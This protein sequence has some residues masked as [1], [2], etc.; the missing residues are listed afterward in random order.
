M[1]ECCGSENDDEPEPHDM[2]DDPKPMHL[3]Q[4]HPSTP[5]VHNPLLPD[6]NTSSAQVDGP[7][8]GAQQAEACTT[9]KQPSQ[10]DEV[11]NLKRQ[12]SVPLGSSQFVNT[13][14]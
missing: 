9:L 8:G 3:I 11:P 10:F 5:P 13:I 2:P 14:T 4:P 6:E 7:Q 12:K 1:V